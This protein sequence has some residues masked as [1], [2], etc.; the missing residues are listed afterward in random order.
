[1]EKKEE[2][3]KEQRE[4]HKQS[5]LEDAISRLSKQADGSAIAQC[6][7]LRDQLK[8]CCVKLQESGEA[9]VKSLANAC[10]KLVSALDKIK[11]ECIKA[12]AL[13]QEDMALDDACE[14]AC[15]AVKE[16]LPFMER[17]CLS[18]NSLDSDSPVAQYQVG[19]V[20]E[21][22]SVKME[23]LV[24]LAAKIVADAI[25]SLSSSEA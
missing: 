9:Q 19:E 18:I 13:G 11:E 4:N 21:Q 23:K 8:I 25:S 7:A 24:G 6:S 1:M 12:E 22:T 5:A 14:K 15:G 2:E 17:L 3:L 16:I 10:D 20:L